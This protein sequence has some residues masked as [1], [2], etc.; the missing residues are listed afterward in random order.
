M[1]LLVG[2][3]ENVRATDLKDMLVI[4]ANAANREVYQTQN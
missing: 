3:F 4:Y 1:N 2:G